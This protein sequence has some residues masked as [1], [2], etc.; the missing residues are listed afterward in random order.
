MYE[1]LHSDGKT[2]GRINYTVWSDVFSCANCA[3]EIVFV[4]EALDRTTG[5]IRDT[6]PCPYCGVE[7]NK[8]GLNLLYETVFDRVINQTVSLPKRVP[9]FINYSVQGTRYE[10]T[11]DEKDALT[12]RS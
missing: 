9:V 5:S 2:V 1:T 8:G 12:T 11:P 7:S 4:K 10:K 6:F 3:K